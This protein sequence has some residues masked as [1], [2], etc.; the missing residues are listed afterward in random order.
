MGRVRRSQ[1]LAVALLAWLWLGA[2]GAGAERFY[3]IVPQQPLVDSDVP[4]LRDAG[5]ESTRLLIG[6][7]QVEREPRKFDFSEIDRELAVLAKARVEAVPFLYGTPAWLEDQARRPPLR[8]KRTR[9]AWQRFVR[10]TVARYG[11]GGSFVKRTKGARPV[12]YWQV[13]NEPNIYG[14]WRPKPNA[15]AYG[16]LLA[17]SREAIEDRDPRARIV[18]GGLPP[19]SRGIDP[20]E[21]LSQ[22]LAVPGVKR[23]FDLAAAHPYGDDVGDML[24]RVYEL[25]LILNRAQLRRRGLMVTEFGWGSAGYPFSPIQTPEGQAKVVRDSLAALA[26]RR[27]RWGLKRIYWFA[28]RDRADAPEACFFCFSTG[29]IGTDGEGKPS[30]YEYKAAARG[31]AEGAQAARRGR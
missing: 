24:D 5:V 19:T 26:E 28:W 1:L 21:Y 23:N 13:W 8:N 6:W 30:W 18:L 20:D 3:G 2:Q 12:R 15:A 22:L 27:D 7:A 31:T 4:P 17:L 14:F 25:R 10:R 9:R 29:L 11:A 16:E